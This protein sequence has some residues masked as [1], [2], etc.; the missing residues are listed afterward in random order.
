MGGG[1]V[2]AALMGVL[3]LGVGP[4]DAPAIERRT[5]PAS[6]TRQTDA[7]SHGTRPGAG[8]HPPKRHPVAVATG[9]G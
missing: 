2:G 6:V 7:P 8:R 3:A 9:R 5:P 4:A 1:A